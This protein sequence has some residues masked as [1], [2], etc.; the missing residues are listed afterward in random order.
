MI[1][2]ISKRKDKN[3][4]IISIDTEKVFD[5]IQHSFMTKALNKLGLEGTYFNTVKVIYEKSTV[6]ISHLGKIESF[7]PKVRNKIMMSILTTF[8]KYSTG[9]PIHSNQTTKEIKGIQIGKEEVKRSLCA[10]D[11]IPYIENL[12]DSTQNLLELINSEK[13]QDSKLNVQKSVIFLYTN[14]Q[15]VE[16]EINNSIYNCTI[17]SKIPGNKPN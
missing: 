14:N 6:T 10:D 17:N 7:P 16:R 3:H 8:I 5:K 1:D 12:K 9:N 13:L 11:M 4:T 15:S 2:H